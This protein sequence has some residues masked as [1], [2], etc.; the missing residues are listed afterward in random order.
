[1]KRIIPLLQNGCLAA[2]PV[3]AMLA[4]CVSED[5]PDGTDYRSV[6]AQ[7]SAGISGNSGDGTR[8]AQDATDATKTNWVTN[9]LI[10]VYAYTGTLNADGSG[11]YKAENKAYKAVSSAASSNFVSNTDAEKIFFTDDG[12]WKFFAYWPKQT[13]TDNK[14]SVDC[15]NDLWSQNLDILRTKGTD[16]STT[17]ENPKISFSGDQEFQHRMARVRILIVPDNADDLDKV[18]G[19]TTSSPESRYTLND[20]YNFSVGPLKWTA[21]YDPRADSFSDH[22]SIEVQSLSDKA[23]GM[24]SAE[25][26]KCWQKVAA[27][28]SGALNTNAH[29]LIHEFYILPQVQQ[30]LVFTLKTGTDATALKTEPNSTIFW[31]GKAYDFII[32]V[33]LGVKMEVV[34]CQISDMVDYSVS[35]VFI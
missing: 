34:D 31:G 16:C 35:K 26:A 4:S 33:S 12:T 22:G 28:T 27:N 17:K 9:D 30:S 18:F 15:Y 25:G 7:I 6:E 24:S 32:S 5:A 8:T 19:F 1:M 14:F 29:V 13:L 21:K 2:L 20:G 11:T 23:S 10:G 3:F